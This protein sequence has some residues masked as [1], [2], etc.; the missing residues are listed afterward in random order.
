MTIDRI[1]SYANTQLMLAHVMKAENG[2]DI[3]N[4][5]VATGKLAD[6]YAGYRD[7]TAIME[8]ARSASAR[9]DANAAAATQAAARLDLQ[10]SHLSQLS[11]LADQIRQALT[12]AAADRDGTSLMT[13]LENYFDQVISIL[14]AKD[15]NGYIYAGENSQTPPVAVDSLAA[16]GGLPAVSNAF[17]N[18]TL[19]TQVK[20]GDSH[21]VEV[22]L[23]ASELATELF[24][25]LR[26]VAQFD[27]GIDGPF[28]GNSPTTPAQQSFIESMLVPAI[29][30][31]H[32]VNAMAAANGIHYQTVKQA[33]EQL[34][35]ASVVYKGFVS[36]IEDVDMAKALAQLN[37]HQVALQAAFQVTSTLNRLSLLNYLPLV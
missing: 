1:G 23:L 20:V 5:Q 26:Q 34:E 6:N 37:Q 2:L 33:M 12:K 21:T 28:S 25:V 11:E 31:Q 29:N 24:T 17:T 30:A 13:Q 32:G 8:A 22:G 3:A 9:A 18:G 19:K 4:R 15:A 36:S 35:A 16:L 10:D 14:N 7:K 27:A